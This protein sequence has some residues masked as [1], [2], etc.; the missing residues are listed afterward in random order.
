M[1]KENKFKDFISL[2]GGVIESLEGLKN[3]SKQRIKSKIL[4]ALKEYDFVSR[5]EFN[6]IKEIV[7]KAREENG[8]LENKIKNLENKFKKK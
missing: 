2:I 5:N 4:N 3:Q 1:N 8:R 7:I 6:E